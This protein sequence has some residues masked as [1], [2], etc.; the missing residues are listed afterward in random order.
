MP[1]LIIHLFR[2]GDCLGNLSTQKL[3]VAFPQLDSKLRQCLRPAFRV[4]LPKAAALRLPLLFPQVFIEQ[5][6]ASIV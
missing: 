6:G 2:R 1:Q 5:A 4:S 3:T